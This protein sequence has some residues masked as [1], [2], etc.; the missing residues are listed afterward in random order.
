MIKI[1]KVPV[2]KMTMFTNLFPKKAK[3]A[4][5]RIRTAPHKFLYL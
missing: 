3:K 2:K 1:A 5:R 4:P